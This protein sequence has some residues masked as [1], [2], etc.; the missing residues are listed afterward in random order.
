MEKEIAKLYEELTR[1][2][3]YD[4]LTKTYHISKEDYQILGLTNETIRNKIKKISS[5]LGVNLEYPN[6][7]LPDIKGQEL[8]PE[9]NHIKSILETTLNIKERTILEQRRIQIRN[10]II[11]YNI[12]LIK[13]IINRRIY[14]T[15]INLINNSYNIEELYQIGYE[16]LINY[17]DNHYLEREQIKYYIDT[18]LNTK[19][20]RE[21]ESEFG[22]NTHLSNELIKLRNLPQ[23][24]QEEKELSEDFNLEES[25]EEELFINILNYNHLD[26]LYYPIN[27]LEKLFIIKEEKENLYKILKT[28]KTEEQYKTIS[29]TF[30]LNDEKIHSKNEI[31]SII[32]C[33]PETV[34]K[35]K[36]RSIT[37]LRYPTRSKYIKQVMGI[38]I[39]KEEI[40]NISQIKVKEEYTT[41]KNLELFLLKQL[42]INLLENLTENIKPRLKEALLIYLGYQ[43]KSK[44]YIS[45]NYKYL[46]DVEYSLNF[47]RKK[48]TETFVKQNKNEEITNYLDYL[49]YYYLNKP[50]TITKTRIK[51]KK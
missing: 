21:I 48:I 41:L 10:L 47:I 43:E 25:R 18:F 50:K 16:S 2:A 40:E 12:E 29:L 30:G 35:L 38:A 19:I 4:K 9:Y 6:K 36:E 1:V 20:K 37:Q 3:I 7:P 24:N 13:L 31:S 51:S 14:N 22:I 42:D 28:L 32:K 23:T 34:R 33:S 8:F 46:L 44:K 17:I 5:I 45:D 39:S 49:M 15:N 11:E 27:P 26:K